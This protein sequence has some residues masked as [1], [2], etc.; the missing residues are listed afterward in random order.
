MHDNQTFMPLTCG[1]CGS[2]NVVNPVNDPMVSARCQKCGH[3][4]E[5]D[6]AQQKRRERQGPKAYVLSKR[7]GPPTF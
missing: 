7:S 5:S 3:E 4:A 6:F 2:I 1:E